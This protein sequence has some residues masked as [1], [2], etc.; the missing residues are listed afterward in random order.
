MAN[1]FVNY[2]N[3]RRNRT[4][5]SSNSESE[6]PESKRSKNLDE[7]VEEQ[8]GDVII[9]ALEMTGEIA[10]TLKGILE[11][12]QKLDTIE[13][14]V[15]RIETT[16][17]NLE[18][19]IGNLETFQQTA[20]TDMEHLKES[21]TQNESKCIDYQKSCEKKL[22]KIKDALADLDHKEQEI[23]HKLK[24]LTT[25]DLYLEAYS[26]RENIKFNNIPETPSPSSGESGENT[27]AVLRG[28]L[29]KELGFADGS[30]VEIQRVHRL[31]KIRNET[32]RPILAKF[33]RSKDVEKILS[34]GSRLKGTNFQMFRDLPQELVDR[35]RAQ[36]DNYKNAK[37]RGMP[38]SFSRSKPD[39]LYI[40]GKLC[41]PGQILSFDG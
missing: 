16:M 2:F 8:D 22:K 5:N 28:F 14:S 32:P 13:S 34:L 10:G 41:P 7:S 39:Q 23:N 33:L 15:K 12:L 40:R 1:Q 29:E 21:V 9:D 11:K 35:R 37:R 26:R 24:V 18:L 31:G 3:K 19:R 30:T 38:V 6:S 4:P 27:E 17:E 25:K 20:T 36:M